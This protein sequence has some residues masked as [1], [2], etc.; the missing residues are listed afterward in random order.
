MRGLRVDDSLDAVMDAYYT[1]NPDLVGNSGQALLYAVDLMPAG[2]YIGVAHRD[3]QRI[4]VLE[5]AVHEQLQTGDEG[6]TDAGILY[7]MANGNVTAIRVYGL[8]SRVQAADVA[9]DMESARSLGAETTYSRVETSLVGGELEPFN[10]EDMIFSGIDFPTLT[11]DDAVAAFGEPGEDV[12]LEDD[13]GYMRVMQFESCEVIFLYDSAQ[14]NGCV[15]NMTIDSD[16]MEG[17]RSVRVGDT[18][19][20]VLGRF[21][22]GEGEYQDGTEVLYGSE[23]SGDFGV[24]Q[25]GEDASVILRYGALSEDGTPVLMYLNLKEYELSEIILMINE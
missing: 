11:P 8:D 14:Q 18:L 19:A 9:A 10:S 13:D 3:G 5:Y 2:A 20:S 16:R 23:E 7:T 1:E 4:Q 25:Y 22:N 15:K 17:P 12:W 24:A 21:R 6:Y